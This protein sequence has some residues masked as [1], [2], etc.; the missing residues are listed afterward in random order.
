MNLLGKTKNF[1]DLW[2]VAAVLVLVVVGIVFVYSASCYTAKQN[3]N[4]FY[5]VGKQAV[6]ALVGC[7]ALVA[8]SCVPL[9]FVRKF[10]LV[11]V[12]VSAALLCLV[13]VP[14]VGIENYGAKRW[15]GFGSFSFQPS[16]LAKFALVLFAAEFMSHH[17]MGKFVNCI[18][19]VGV[20][21]VL[22]LLI[23]LEPNMSVTVCVALITLC[24]MFVG[25]VKW[26]HFFLMVAPV[27][28]A[29]PLLVI[30]EPY[31]MQRLLA[32]VDPWASP[33]GEGY[34]LVQ[35]LY[36]LGSG[37]WFGVGLFNSRQKYRF[38]PFAESD[39]VFAVIGE[40]IGLVGCACLFALFVFVTLRGVRIALN[41]RDKFTFLLSSGITAVVAV[42]SAV[43]FAV[44]T[45]SV[46]PTGLPLPFISY[47]GTSLVVF[48]AA[49][50]LLVN[51]SKQ[52][53]DK[54][55]VGWI[56]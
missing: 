37:G 1:G 47:G 42:Q 52:C 49:M 39:F 18:P 15:I 13:F 7:V 32:F 6:G 41:C 43:N 24:L 19:V 48:M 56:T 25:G 17:D 10:W 27:V 29:A 4:E 34:Q 16:E 14:H 28:V 50:G 9:N 55:G 51:C 26:K 2:L 33:K 36:A 40:E 11:G 45:G 30:A 46:P 54:R 20:G 35:S 8:C 44:V 12:V 31:R 23:I 5:Y 22:C 53:F 3:G 38:L 21:G